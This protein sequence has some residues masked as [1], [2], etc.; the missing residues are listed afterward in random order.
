MARING[1]NV[2]HLCNSCMKDFS[3]CDCRHL[4]MTWGID[5]D[6][7]ARGADADAVIRCGAYVKKETN[8]CNTCME[9]FPSC[10]PERTV[11]VCEQDAEDKVLDCTGHKKK[12]DAE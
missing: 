10:R 12:E 8:L 3:A 7:Q 2:P 9:T 5:L 6:P 1:E 11:F 4:N